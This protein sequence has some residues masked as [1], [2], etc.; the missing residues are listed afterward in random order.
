M[1]S[2]TLGTAAAAAGLALAPVA[3]EATIPERIAPI[4]GESEIGGGDAKPT[5]IILAVG[6]IGIAL[7]A[8][9][10]DDDDDDMPVST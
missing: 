2:K 1:K 6:A 10:G 8:L 4:A 7:L 9:T 5:L 3:A